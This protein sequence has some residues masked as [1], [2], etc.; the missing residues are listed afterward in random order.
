MSDS[1][2]SR[3]D[4]ATKPLQP[5]K[6]LGELFGEL[7]SDMGTLFRKEVELA[8][9]EAKDELKQGGKAAGMFAGAGLGGWMAVLFLSL[10]LAWLLDQAMNTA[11]AFAIVGVLW[12]V[13]AAVLA[14]SGKKKMAAVKPLPQTTQTLKED[15]QW[16]KTQ[17]S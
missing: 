5:D 11:L 1:D 15:A 17:K 9:L 2:R 3:G 14:A 13:V 6:S 12:A 16:A 10:A 8:K 7:T 4:L